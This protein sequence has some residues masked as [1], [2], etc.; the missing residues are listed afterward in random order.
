[1]GKRRKRAIKNKKAGLIGL[2]ALLI[3]GLVGIALVSRFLIPDQVNWVELTIT[4]VVAGVT[5]IGT[6]VLGI[7]AYWQ[8]QNANEL[9]MLLAKKEMSSYVRVGS[10]AQLL[11]E[12]IDIKSALL[13]ADN[14]PVEY[15][16]CSEKTKKEFYDA[17]KR[18][19]RVLHFSFELL[20]E[21]APLN[22]FKIKGFGF[23]TKLN[24]NLKYKKVFNV[25][26][27]NPNFSV[28]CNPKKQIYVLD[29]YVECALKFFKMLNKDNMLVIDLNGVAESTYG[30]ETKEEISINVGRLLDY[31][32]FIK[33]KKT[34]IDIEIQTIHKGE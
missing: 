13:V 5:Y 11:L 26:N 10:H 14:Y 31:E 33:N 9:S 34:D 23:N 2:I 15:L 20:T 4:A 30:I 16:I 28:Y 25:L 17:E 12:T 21:N 24:E 3:A 7:V 32:T 22:N 29:I 18:N 19:I 6:M 1:M 8:T 27:D